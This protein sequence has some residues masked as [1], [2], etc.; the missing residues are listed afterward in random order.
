MMLYFRKSHRS[1]ELSEVTT[2][3]PGD[4]ANVIDPSNKEIESLV[5]K[6]NLPREF[7]HAALDPKE[8]SRIDHIGNN[9]LF[10][11]RIPVKENSKYFVI[12]IGVVITES[13]IFTITAKPN[14]ILNSFLTEKI[15]GF[16]T[17]KR[18]RFVLYL[19]QSAN[20][21]FDKYVEEVYSYTER[22]EAKLLR[23]ERNIEV[24]S[25]L[26]VQKTITYFHS[27][28]INNG[29]LF[30]RIIANNK[31]IEIYPDDRE[32]LEDMIIEN[33][34][35]LETVTIFMNNL[36]NTMDAYA[37]IISNNL[38]MTMKFLTSLTIILTLP[39]IITSFYGMNVKLPFAQSP[40]AYVLII[41]V[42]VI[43]VLVAL[44]SFMKRNWL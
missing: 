42:C 44:Y 29:V 27:A 21:Y 16:Y 20:R 6:H 34:E 17:T 35:L 7:V 41:L 37:S 13:N 4:W 26:E 11:I 39:T 40:V 31:K 18:L 14:Q 43:S 24:V 9:K 3:K 23:S 12:P 32:L 36:G 19:I 8:R 5:L 22:L 28:L 30:E 15:D 2:L 25:F 1:D 33:K 38:N 10:I